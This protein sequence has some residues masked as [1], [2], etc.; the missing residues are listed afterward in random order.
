M[1]R[2]FLGASVVAGLIVAAAAFYSVGQPM[3]DAKTENRDGP[4]NEMRSSAT[5]TPIG[6]SN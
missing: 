3:A 2:R 6:S 5:A 4:A 1:T